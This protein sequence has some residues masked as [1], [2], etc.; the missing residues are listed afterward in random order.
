MQAANDVAGVQGN[1]GFEGS[2]PQVTGE[3]AGWWPWMYW[4]R[5]LVMREFMPRFIKVT[6]LIGKINCKFGFRWKTWR[7]SSA[8][9]GRPTTAKDSPFVVAFG[10]HRCGGVG[11]GSGRWAGVSLT[12]AAE[13]GR[14][15]GGSK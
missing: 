6:R 9:I 10:L 15:M 13:R 5:C 14:R 1:F 12:I 2:L 8:S 7:N 11:R 3:M 4:L